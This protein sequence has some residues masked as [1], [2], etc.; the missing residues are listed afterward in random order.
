[1][2]RWIT[3]VGQGNVRWKEGPPA[4]LIDYRDRDLL[5]IG[6]ELMTP[7]PRRI[8]PKTADVNQLPSARR[9]VKVGHPS[10]RAGYEKHDGPLPLLRGPLLESEPRSSCVHPMMDGYARRQTLTTVLNTARRI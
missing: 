7:S 2:S 9:F 10:A 8:E 1:M 3:R 5:A 4:R 6:R